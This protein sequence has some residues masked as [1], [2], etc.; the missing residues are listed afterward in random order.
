MQAKQFFIASLLIFFLGLSLVCSDTA[1]ADPL[2]LQAVFD[3]EYIYATRPEAR[4]LEIL[5]TTAPETDKR[6]A[7]VP[8]NLALVIDTSGSMGDEN[9]LNYVKQAAIAML[10]RLRPEDRLAIVTY[11]NKAKV[12]LPS[13]PVRMERETQSL[14]ESLRAD[15]G[16]NLGAGL[17][18][19]YRQ[20]HEFAGAKTINRLLLLS[21]GKA[22]VGMTSSTELSRLVL[23]QADAGISL[24]SFGVGLDFNED[25]MAAL[26]ESGRGMYYFIDH[27]Q[28]MRTILAKEFKS[29]EQLV[30]ADIKITVNLSADFVIDQVFANNFEKN[31]NTISVRFG[32]LAAG[33]LRR[34]QI[35]FQPRQREPG[36]V[37]NAARVD[38]SYMTP[39]DSGSY[40]L[41]QSIGLTYTED[42]KTAATHQDKAVSER[43]AIF[44]A[45]YARDKAAKAFD[46]GDRSTAD[47]IL[48]KA[49]KKLES[50][51][52]GSIR[53]Q[54]EVSDMET[55]Q[56]GLGQS[57]PAS[58]RAWE[59]K[60]VK[61]RKHVIEGC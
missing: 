15:G 40:S 56:E 48:N 28:S 57:M 30:A 27:P 31:G 18:E 52:A 2:Q 49:K 7:R 16:T 3:N 54:K 44:E 17:I 36:P 22:N 14:I 38:V 61:H 20:L 42:K 53:A 4:Y 12:I 58:K 43:S 26:S 39:G 41:S 13:S 47:S 50:I 23:D 9:K 51:A 1:L 29:V 37:N 33:E 10:N 25:L 32:D 34:L 21:D 35:R 46:R 19:G 6:Q 60:R 55:Y 11:N 59:Q 5:V 8:L 45:N 24:S